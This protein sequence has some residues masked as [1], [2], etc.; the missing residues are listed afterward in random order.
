VIFSSTK[1][2]KGIC[3]FSSGHLVNIFLK[4]GWFMRNLQN[5]PSSAPRCGVGR[6]IFEGALRFRLCFKAEQA[7]NINFA[8]GS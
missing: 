3:L 6:Q 7:P 1:P 5:S 4:H 2:E 8:N